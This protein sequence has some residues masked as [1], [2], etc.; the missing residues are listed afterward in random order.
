MVK[1]RDVTKYVKEV[2]SILDGW[3][4]ESLEDME[5]YD[6]ESHSKYL[7]KPLRELVQKAYEAGKN[8]LPN[9]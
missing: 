8:E 3:F 4:G 2:D 1:E 5:P 7:Y 9:E 6:Y